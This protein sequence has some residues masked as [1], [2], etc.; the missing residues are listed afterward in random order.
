MLPGLAAADEAR[1]LDTV[2]VPAPIATESGSATKTDTPLREI[3]QSISIISHQ[4]IED[5]KLDD[6][7]DVLAN[8]TGVTSTHSMACRR[9]WCRTGATVIPASIWACTTAWKWC[10][11][12]PA[13][14]VVPAIRR[15]R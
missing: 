11:V 9:R 13:C 5:Q 3:P 10:A 6:I 4:R 14:S 8:T 1:T 15:H 2:Q 12:P 7:I